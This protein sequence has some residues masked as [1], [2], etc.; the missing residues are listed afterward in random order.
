MYV[1]RQWGRP[2]RSQGLVG[3]DAETAVADVLAVR[4][5]LAVAGDLV[6]PLSAELHDLLVAAADEV[7]PHPDRLSEGWAPDQHQT[8]VLVHLEHELGAARSQVGQVVLVHLMAGDAHSAG[9]EEQSV[10]EGR[11]HVAAERRTG[12]QAELRADHRGVRRSEAHTSELQ[13]LMRISYA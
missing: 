10:L 7:P 5:E 9:V 12:A 6:L 11:V 8:G 1:V 13:S 3:H 2:E 4:D